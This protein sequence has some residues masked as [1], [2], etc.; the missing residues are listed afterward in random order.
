MARHRLKTLAPFFEAVLS[1]AKPF[2]VRLNDRGFAVGDTLHLIETDRAG[3]E[4]GRACERR[5]TY[6][7]DG[8]QFGVE[9]DYVVMGVAPL[10]ASGPRL[11]LVQ[12]Y[13]DPF[14]QA[15][16]NQMERAVG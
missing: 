10:P 12:A 14:A 16:R 8:G 15:G 1:G 9:P 5:V 4:T 7:L 6:I 13:G 2:E 3:A 11:S